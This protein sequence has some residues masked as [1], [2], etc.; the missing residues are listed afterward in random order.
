MNPDM[1]LARVLPFNSSLKYV[2]QVSAGKTISSSC[3]APP[4]APC[5]SL[6]IFGD[7]LPTVFVQE[8]RLAKYQQHTYTDFLFPAEKRRKFVRELLL[9]SVPLHFSST[10]LQY[11]FF[12]QLHRFSNREN[13][14]S[15]FYGEASHCICTV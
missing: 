3:S 1:Y 10:Y 4:S 12:S 15:F 11:F 13:C 14:A 8:R 5:L 9:A 6:N 2:G 7:L